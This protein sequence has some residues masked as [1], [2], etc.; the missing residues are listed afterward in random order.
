[1]DQIRAA[2]VWLKRHH[3]WVLTAVVTFTALGCW[4]TA[5]NDLSQRYE[6]SK[7]QIETEFNDVQSLNN[8]PFFQNDE[9]NEEHESR[10]K[11]SVKK[12]RRCGSS[13][14]RRSKRRSSS[15]PTV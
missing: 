10:T 15:G 1:M 5:A 11:S 8:R 7:R 9:V 12:S 2:L 14:T 4:Y 6:E 3:F 13:S